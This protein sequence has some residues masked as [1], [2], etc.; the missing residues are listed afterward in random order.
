M[1]KDILVSLLTNILSSKCVDLEKKSQN[2]EKDL[3]NLLSEKDKIISKKYLYINIII[4]ELNTYFI[5]I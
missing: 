2:E 5:L 3:Q 4:Y 1:S